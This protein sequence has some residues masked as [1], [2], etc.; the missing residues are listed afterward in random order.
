MALVL[1][2]KG[3]DPLDRFLAEATVK[4]SLD[5][6]LVL[7]RVRMGKST[8]PPPR[9][10]YMGAMQRCR[11]MAIPPAYCFFTLETICFI[12]LSYICSPFGED[13]AVISST[14]L[15]VTP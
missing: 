14:R 10:S 12:S 4:R 11:G 9:E 3:Q 2:P 1:P 7:K 15:P 13:H 6:L 8:L 5:T